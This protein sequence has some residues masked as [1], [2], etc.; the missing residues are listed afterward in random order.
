[1]FIKIFFICQTLTACPDHDIATMHT[2]AAAHFNNMQDCN[3]VL[4]AQPA[5]P[6]VGAKCEQV[7]RDTDYSIWPYCPDCISGYGY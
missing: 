7:A 2:L 4:S 6:D 1:M 3:A 5:I